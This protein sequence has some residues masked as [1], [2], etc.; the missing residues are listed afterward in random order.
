MRQLKSRLVAGLVLAVLVPGASLLIAQTPDVR[1][2]AKALIDKYRKEREEVVKSGADKKLSTELLGKADAIAKE[3]E[4][5]FGVERFAEAREAMH[6]ARW[7]LPTLP[8]NLPENLERVLG[9]FKLRHSALPGSTGD[10]LCVAY[11]PDGTLLATGGKDAFAR[12]WDPATGRQLR[13]LRGHTDSV[14]SLA[15]SKDGK[16][17]V[18]GGADKTVRLWDADTGKFIK[19]LGSAEDNHT[20]FVTSVAISPDG[21]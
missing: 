2:E 14:R 15:F 19:Q 10:V 21:S 3:A 4:S 1:E 6:R 13:T 12:I 17:I 8:T 20:E 5:A 9:V 16:K 11:N 18:T 7:L